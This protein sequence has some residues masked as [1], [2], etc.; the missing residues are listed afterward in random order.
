[1]GLRNTVTGGPL[2]RRVSRVA[3]ITDMEAVREVVEAL[4][5]HA[6]SPEDRITRFVGECREHLESRGIDPAPSAVEGNVT[7]AGFE[8]PDLEWYCARVV[9]L[10]YVLSKVA[11]R[12]DAWLAAGLAMDIGR[13]SVQMSIGGFDAKADGLAR[14]RALAKEARSKKAAT[15]REPAR[16]EAKRIWTEN[17]A[18]SASD[19]ARRLHKRGIANTVGFNTLRRAI[20]KSASKSW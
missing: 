4:K 12:G 20:A 7:D 3:D 6:C 10:G 18:L 11:A 19:V 15:W 5:E 9:S 16:T 17:P 13:A 14:G 1:M 2:R 8:H